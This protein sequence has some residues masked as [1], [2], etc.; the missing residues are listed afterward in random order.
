MIRGCLRTLTKPSNHL[1]SSLCLLFNLYMCKQFTIIRVSSFCL[2]SFF[3]FSVPLIKC[4][5]LVSSKK[6]LISSLVVSKI[7]VCV[8]PKFGPRGWISSTYRVPVDEVKIENQKIEDFTNDI[9]TFIFC[10]RICVCIS[11]PSSCLITPLIYY[12][13]LNTN[14]FYCYFDGLS[15]PVRL[16]IFFLYV[17]VKSYD[18]PP[19]INQV[20]LTIIIMVW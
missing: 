10:M 14:I 2:V 6:T 11:F 7:L 15:N 13:V 19:H 12:L 18:T 9:I 16:L 4:L 3:S 5:L 1:N 20:P 17:F 8:Y